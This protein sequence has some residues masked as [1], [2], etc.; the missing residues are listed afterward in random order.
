MIFGNFCLEINEIALSLKV[1]WFCIKWEVGHGF[2][3][4]TTVE[5]CSSSARYYNPAYIT[6][7][8]AS[9]CAFLL[10]ILDVVVCVE[11]Y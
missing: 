2:L 3:S 8:R 9:N 6:V 5:T 7:P 10:S 4:A 11:N 1:Q